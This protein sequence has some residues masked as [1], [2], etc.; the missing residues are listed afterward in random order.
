MAP[1]NLAVAASMLNVLND[2]KA[3]IATACGVAVT[4]INIIA[5]SSGALAD[6]ITAGTI[7]PD[8]FL[9]VSDLTQPPMLAVSGAGLVASSVPVV[10]NNL[11]LIKNRQYGL[12][13]PIDSFGNVDAVHTG[14]VRIFI[15]DPAG[16]AKV[17]AGQFARSAFQYF[18]S[19]IWTWIS[20]LGNATISTMNN[21]TTVLRSVAG[22]ITPP[23]E[24]S[25]VSG[26]AIGAVYATDASSFDIMT[27]PVSPN[28]VEIIAVA[29]CAVNCTISY[30]AAQINT[31]AN[32][33]AAGLFL[34]FITSPTAWAYFLKWGFIP[35]NAM[36]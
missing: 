27:P 1:F 17:P 34:T 28:P 8:I 9:P 6:Q 13:V 15:A 30:T 23:G 5:D 25:P 3:A 36:P 21:V 11:V 4:D 2:M 24:A 33:T 10:R 20:T 29:P 16:T 7:K 22:V 12:P 18:G 32:Q 31:G 35:L 14:G 26:P 19:A